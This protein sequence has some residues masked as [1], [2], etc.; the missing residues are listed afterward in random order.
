MIRKS[1]QRFSEKII[2]IEA[3]PKYLLVKKAALREAVRSA[4]RQRFAT[5][6]GHVHAASIS[7]VFL[8]DGDV[9]PLMW[10]ASDIGL[11]LQFVGN[12]IVA[13]LRTE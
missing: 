9:R 11:L 5:T 3:R 7:M 8:S 13:L 2:R 6:A 12:H 4:S 10:L 1:A